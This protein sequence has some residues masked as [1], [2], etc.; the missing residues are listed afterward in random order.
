MRDLGSL[1]GPWSGFFLQGET[2]TLMTARLSFA[3]QSISGNGKDRDG[4][5]R[6]KGMYSIE[7]NRVS[8]TK[9]YRWHSVVFRGSWNG[10]FIEGDTTF[11]FLFLREHGLFELWPQRDEETLSVLEVL[12]QAGRQATTAE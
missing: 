4:I 1:S 2:R 3:G 9:R 12:A 8:L 6:V 5:F 7:N 10:E 11:R